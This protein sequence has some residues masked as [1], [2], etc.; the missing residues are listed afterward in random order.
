MDADP[1]D[2]RGLFSRNS[3]TPFSAI[4]D[5]LSQTLAGGERH[6]GTFAVSIGSH[7]HYDAETVWIGA[8][9]EEPDD[10]HAHTTLFQASHTPTSGAMND[11]DAASRHPAVRT[12]SSATARFASS[13]A[14]STS[15][16][17]SRSPAG[18]AVR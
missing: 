17:T 7:D 10:D 15:A 1:G 2:S 13:R 12:S 5:G 8:V 4:T 11:Q 9:K 18:P 6:N 14:P 16:S 3:G